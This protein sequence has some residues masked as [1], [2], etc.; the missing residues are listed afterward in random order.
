MNRMVEILGTYH[1]SQSDFVPLGLPTSSVGRGPE[2]REKVRHLQHVSEVRKFSG[3]NKV[4]HRLRS[5]L[6][7]KVLTCITEFF[8]FAFTT[9]RSFISV[10][11]K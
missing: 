5:F 11:K 4:S 6:A 1:A 9:P 8:T 2:G 7:G 3:L 10:W